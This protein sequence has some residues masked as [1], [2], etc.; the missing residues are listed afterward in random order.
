M[1]MLTTWRELAWRNAEALVNAPTP[2][3][4]AVVAAGIE[5]GANTIANVIVLSQSYLPPLSTTASRDAYCSL[6]K[7]DAA[8]MAYPFGMPTP[9]AG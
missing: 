3:A 4:R 8:P 7:A 2:E 6:H 9:Y 1:Q 5:A